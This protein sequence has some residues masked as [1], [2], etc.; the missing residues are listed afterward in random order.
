LQDKKRPGLEP[1][2]GLK[3]KGPQ[4]STE[5]KTSSKH[6]N[7]RETLRLIRANTFDHG[8][9]IVWL[10]EIVESLLPLPAEE[11]ERDPVPYLDFLPLPDDCGYDC[12]ASKADPMCP[13]HFD[14][15]VADA[16]PDADRAVT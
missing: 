8:A 4:L 10:A 6:R 2:L 15:E 1:G 11:P 5:S 16:T 12:K 7:P 14:D 3:E 13:Y 9:A